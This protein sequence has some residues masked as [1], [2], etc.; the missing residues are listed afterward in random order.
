MLIHHTIEIHRTST[1]S[2]LPFTIT[3]IPQHPL[4][5]FTLLIP[6]QPLPSENVFML[7]PTPYGTKWMTLIE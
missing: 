1:A 7:F 5:R 6:R 2:S 4:M 3:A